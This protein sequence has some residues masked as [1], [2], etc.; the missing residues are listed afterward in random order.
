MP[1]TEMPV[2]SGSELDPQRAHGRA[3]GNLPI[4]TQPNG[5]LLGGKDGEGQQRMVPSQPQVPP[6]LGTVAPEELWSCMPTHCLA[7]GSR[8]LKQEG[9][10]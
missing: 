6:L 2:A 5:L 1:T 10:C 3:A 4:Q 9:H 8:G 7:A